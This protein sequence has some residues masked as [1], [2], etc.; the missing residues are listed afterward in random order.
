VACD[1]AL[2]AL[3]VL[4]VHAH[5]YPRRSVA[6]AELLAALRGLPDLEVRSLY[7]LYPRLR[8]RRRCRAP[9]PRAL[10][11]G[12]AAASAVLVH[13][14]R[15]PQALVRRRA[16]EGMGLRRGRHRARGQALPLGGDH[17]RRP[18][19][20]RRDGAPRPAA[21]GVCAR[22]RADGALLR[23]ELAR[24]L[25]RERRAARGL[26]RRAARRGCACAPASRDGSHDG[27][28]GLPRRA[29]VCVPIAAASGWARCW[30][31]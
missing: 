26:R 18:R 14:T 22:D 28:P 13:D 19:G 6:G 3:M 1:H 12:G 2:G 27:G 24:A 7:E 17:G 21:R 20:V 30:D 8:H 25:R 29:V 9:R 15:A 31:T 10:K 16:G 5:P 23:H 11:P 4:V